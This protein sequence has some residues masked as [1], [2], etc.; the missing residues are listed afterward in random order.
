MVEDKAYN[1][2]VTVA[3][4]QIPEGL[5]SMFEDY[6]ETAFIGIAKVVM[7]KAYAVVRE[8]WLSMLIRVMKD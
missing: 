3:V 1:S 7:A 4:V 5:G 2:K 8:W 6:K